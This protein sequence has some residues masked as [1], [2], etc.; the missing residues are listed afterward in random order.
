MI[1]CVKMHGIKT[2]RGER[3]GHALFSVLGLFRFKKLFVLSMRSISLTSV[4]K[5]Y[6]FLVLG[7]KALRLRLEY[8]CHLAFNSN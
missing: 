7:K 1:T 4:D 6:L 8:I 3:A 5:Y 2:K